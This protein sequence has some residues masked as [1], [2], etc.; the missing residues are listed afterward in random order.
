MLTLKINPNRKQDLIIKQ[1]LDEMFLAKQ[2]TEQEDLKEPEI[3]HGGELYKGYKRIE[4]FFIELQK[5]YDGWY[6][7]RCDKYENEDGSQMF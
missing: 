2:L 1:K 6:E 3:S 7:D 4:T 5:L